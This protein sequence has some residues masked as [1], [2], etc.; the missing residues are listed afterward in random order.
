[1]SL[2]RFFVEG[3]HDVGEVVSLEGG[4]AR[5]I[6][7]VLRLRDGD[8]I[9]AIDSSAQ[10]F[11]ARLSIRG[12]DVIARL[13]E[14]F[15]V[16]RTADALRITV[17]QG[18]PKGQKMEF[19]VEKLTELG[20]AQIVPLLSERTIARAGQTKLDRW[21]RLA[22]AAAAQSGRSDVPPIAQPLAFDALLATFG[23]YDLV[24]MP[25]ELAD[26]VPLREALPALLP[27]ALDVLVLIG[28]E[29]GFSHDEAAA[30]NAAGAHLVW[31]GRTILRTETAAMMLVAVLSYLSP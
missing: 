23:D 21:G 1:M 31:L 25:W 14:L 6:A 11:R 19:V 29:G 15:A 4:D 12:S 17:A 13:E 3:Q 26:P 10:R 28:P 16:G 22:K 30:A 8:E 24:L 5:K 9:E 20:V 27:G 2:P 18:V 7:L